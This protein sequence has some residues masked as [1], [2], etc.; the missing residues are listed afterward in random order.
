M[1]PHGDKFIT[2]LLHSVRSCW[3]KSASLGKVS[4]ESSRQQHLGSA[5]CLCHVNLLLFSDTIAVLML[6]PFCEG[7]TGLSL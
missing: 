1:S 5:A 4:K 2:A 3:Q 6:Q 7:D